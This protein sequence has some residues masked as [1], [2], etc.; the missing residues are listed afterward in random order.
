VVAW[1][2]DRAK[3][4]AFSRSGSHTVPI[5]ENC[6]DI[7]GQDIEAHSNKPAKAIELVRN[8]LSGP[9]NERGSRIPSGTVI[10]SRYAQFVAELPGWCDRQRLIVSQL[11]YRDN[12]LLI[13]DWLKT[14]PVA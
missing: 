5:S 3:C 12:Y 4:E 14:N 6:S 13:I 8:W 1:P 2:Y 7:A 10:A 11:T 9:A